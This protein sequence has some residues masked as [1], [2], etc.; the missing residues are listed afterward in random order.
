[1]GAPARSTPGQGLAARRVP[2]GPL[3]LSARWRRL[4]DH[5]Q[6]EG[7][8]SLPA[9]ALR[10]LYW[11]GQFYR[12]GLHLL[13]ARRPWEPSQERLLR[14]LGWT[15]PVRT[16]GYERHDAPLAAILDSLS[17]DEASQSLSV[18][19]QG[20]VW[21]RDRLSRVARLCAERFAGDFV[22]IGAFLGETTVRLAQV[23]QACGR[24]VLVVD[25]WE[26]GT[27][28]C[29]GVEYDL[30]LKNTAPYRDVI[31]VVRASSQDYDAMIP[32]RQ[33]PLSFAYVDGLHTDG[34][35]LSDILTVRHTA[36]IVAVDDLTWSR[37]V[38]QAFRMGA[39]LTGRLPIHSPLCREGYLAYRYRSAGQGGNAAG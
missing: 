9:W 16:A 13:A 12:T 23:A 21:Q 11:N 1:M 32:V 30:F 7:W 38:Q 2:D 18:L 26:A 33:R 39:S 31:D 29:T 27:Q 4:R 20:S 24:R 25:P 3:R 17:A 8:W 6:R 36:G 28:N 5:V 35:C 15:R 14:R 34:A 37:E 22:E 19:L 10:W